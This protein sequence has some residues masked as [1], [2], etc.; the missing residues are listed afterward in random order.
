MSKHSTFSGL[1]LP[2][3][4]LPNTIGPCNASYKYRSAE[5]A[6]Q[7]DDK[8][9]VAPLVESNVQM[10]L[11][12]VLLLLAATELPAAA[13]SDITASAPPAG[14]YY[15]SLGLFLLTVPGTLHRHLLLVTEIAP[16]HFD[17]MIADDVAL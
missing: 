16:P 9:S 14:S 11:P 13:A 4:Q 5:R 2:I 17:K 15:V 3:R 6:I 12:A 7:T 1:R 8:T 10:Q